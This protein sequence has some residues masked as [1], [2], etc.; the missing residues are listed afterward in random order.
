[1]WNFF[2]Y[3]T[4]VP[5][6]KTASMSVI[7][8]FGVLNLIGSV[9]DFFYSFLKWNPDSKSNANHY[10]SIPPIWYRIMT[11]FSIR[12]NIGKLLEARPKDFMATLDA[13]RALSVFWLIVG[14]FYTVNFSAISMHT[15][16]E[17]DWTATSRV[18]TESFY[19]ITTSSEFAYDSF[20]TVGCHG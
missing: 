5:V 17:N 20:F 7:I 4:D 12:H 8:I 13:I 1:M 9:G 10:E 6:L 14:Y 16:V 2:R 3:P 18:L 11:L 19:Q 15:V